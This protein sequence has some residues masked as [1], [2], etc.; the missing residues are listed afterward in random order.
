[1]KKF[2]FL[3]VTLCLLAACSKSPTP[4]TPTQPEPTE[5]NAPTAI[6]SP[7]PTQAATA[8]IQPTPTLTPEPVYSETRSKI[9]TRMEAYGFIQEEFLS[10]AY[11]EQLQTRIEKYGAAKSILTLE[12]HGNNYSMYGGAYALTPEAFYEQMDYLMAN[13]YH[14]A[15]LPEIEGFVYGWLDLPVRSVI[16]TTDSGYSSQT[17]MDTIIASFQTLEETYGYKPH[18]NSFVWTKSMLPE[19]TIR[20]LDNSCWKAM[21]TAKES[22]YFSFGTHTES[23]QHF[24]DLTPEEIIADLQLSNQKIYDNLGVHVYAIS[25]PHESCSTEIETLNE[26]GITLAWGGRSKPILVNFAGKSDPAP[27]CLPRMF[28]PNPGGIS[29]RPEGKTLVEM[30]ELAEIAP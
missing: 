11:W 22:G 12:F 2:R 19:E 30:L 6:L 4:T 3:F 13:D 27:L 24:S 25:W 21:Q 28:P 29:S 15:T 26:L 20:C 17:S 18:M 14:F 1:M 5:T 9:R 23:H 8:T 16:L 7:T 10:D